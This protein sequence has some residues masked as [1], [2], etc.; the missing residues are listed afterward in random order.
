MTKS[1]IIRIFLLLIV[2]STGA[3]A[4]FGSL[5]SK[6]KGSSECKNNY[7]KLNQ[8]LD[9]LEAKKEKD[10]MT[11]NSFQLYLKTANKHLATIKKKCADDDVSKETKLIE[12]YKLAAENANNAK[13]TEVVDAKPSES[14]KRD[15]GEN[16]YFHNLYKLMFKIYSDSKAAGD[17]TD[18]RSSHVESILQGLSDLDFN[19]EDYKDRASK[20]KEK[21]AQSQIKYINEA[22]ADYDRFISKSSNTYRWHLSSLTTYGIKGNPGEELK[23]LNRAKAFCEILLKVSPDNPIAGNWLNEVES[24]LDKTKGS[25]VTLNEVHKEYLDQ[26]VF[27]DKLVNPKKL[28]KSD[29]SAKFKSG[30][31]IYAYLLLSSTARKQ[32]DGYVWNNCKVR[33]NNYM[34]APENDMAFGFTTKM[35]DSRIVILP[36]L[37]SSEFKSKYPKEFSQYAENNKRTLETIAEQFAAAGAF[38]STTFE[39]TLKF[40]DSGAKV[41]GRFE[42]DQSGGTEIS[43]SILK[44][45]ENERLKHN[46]LPS[47]GMKDATLEQDALNIIRKR[48]AGNGNMYTK[49]IIAHSGWSSDRETTGIEIGRSIVIAIVSK[50]N[51]G[52]CMYQ[53]HNF[54]QDKLNNQFSKTLQWKGAGDNTY[55]DCGNI[56]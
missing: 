36:I 51:D 16:G 13:A 46:K 43:S 27:S 56:K 30:Q 22:L 3:H 54:F 41:S 18:L 9:K 6:L 28:K 33:I 31:Y 10:E 40:R 20:E 1:Q 42:Y 15:R 37:P 52:T 26:I 44:E 39:M 2:F 19:P 55:L 11:S 49:A 48:S 50:N 47:A 29:L 5:K 34:V 24:H 17:A 8:Y 12:A 32:T 23:V 35:Q 14:K 45:G 53:Y 38:S 21:R 7:K 4:Q 25:I